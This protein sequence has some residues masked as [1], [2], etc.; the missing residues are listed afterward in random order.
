ME[1]HTYVLDDLSGKSCEFKDGTHRTHD[2]NFMQPNN[3]ESTTWVKLCELSYLL[4]PA[5]I[6]MAFHLHFY[7]TVIY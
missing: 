3:S 6:S 1:R 2:N 5:D 4:T 7:Y